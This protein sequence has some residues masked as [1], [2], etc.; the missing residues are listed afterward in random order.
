[1]MQKM[2][3]AESMSRWGPW[4]YLMGGAGWLGYLLYVRRYFVRSGEGTTGTS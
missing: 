4:M 1:M 3:L 2:G